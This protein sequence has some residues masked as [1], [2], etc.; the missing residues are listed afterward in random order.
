MEP[1]SHSANYGADQIDE[2]R[3]SQPAG[4]QN[5]PAYNLKAVVQETGLK[6][7]TLR[8]WERRYGLPQPTRTQSGHRLYSKRDIAILKWLLAR[9]NEGLSISRAVALWQRLANDGIDPIDASDLEAISLGKE[10]LSSRN[11]TTTLDHE[12]GAIPVDQ[13]SHFGSLQTKSTQTLLGTRDHNGPLGS[14]IVELRHSWVSACLNFDE[15]RAEQVV[16]EAFSLFDTEVACLELLFKGIS[17]IGAGWIEG[18]VTAQQEH[19]ASSLATR[20]IHTLLNGTPPP[21]RQGKI[22]IG[23]PPGEEHTFPSNLLALLLRRQGWPVLFLGANIPI[24]NLHATVLAAKPALVI[25]TA[26][27]LHTAATLLEMG[28]VIFESGT[29]LA[30]GGSIFVRSADLQGCIPGYYLGEEIG[31]APLIVEQI[32]AAPR[33]KPAQRRIPIEYAGG[34]ASFRKNRGDIERQV[35]LEMLTYGADQ[36][37]INVAHRCLGQ[38]I[39]AALSLCRV[40]SSES[41]RAD[42]GS[43]LL[44]HYGM[45]IEF[46]DGYLGAYYV[47]TLQNCQD[48][49]SIVMEWFSRL[50]G[51]HH[52]LSR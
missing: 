27:Q 38:I 39:T 4:N 16:T 12:H 50:L 3:T 32:M 11:P 33:I 2:E 31:K 14:Q 24:M 29:P 23:C 36:N 40:A 6:A 30:Y 45:P 41:E 15:T 51:E 26:Q 48:L 22:M 47:A 49:D 52:E 43:L 42:I 25:L 44:N 34:L 9:Q 1:E 46:I 20:R 37:T 35:E 21:T 5:E 7:D 28:N 10:S 19:Y 18:R 8:A 13:S 17:E